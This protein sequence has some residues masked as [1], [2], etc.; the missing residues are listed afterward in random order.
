MRYWS[1]EKELVL[2]IMK[3]LFKKKIGMHFKLQLLSYN[4]YESVLVCISY[5]VN[6]FMAMHPK[7]SFNNYESVLV[8]IISST[9]LWQ[10]ILDLLRCCFYPLGLRA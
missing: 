10:C 7:L 3:Q 4:N 2:N 1:C 9:I 8:C 6:H 5:F